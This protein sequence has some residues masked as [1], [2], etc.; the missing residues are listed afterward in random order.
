MFKLI[1]ALIIRNVISKATTIKERQLRQ[2]F[3]VLYIYMAC[4]DVFQ[5][6]SCTSFNISAL[7]AFFE[8]HKEN[9]LEKEFFSGKQRTGDFD[10]TMKLQC[11]STSN[12]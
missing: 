4:R 10:N 2:P 12:Y 1:N 11:M 9:E 8:D 5:F 3:K 7:V 6:I